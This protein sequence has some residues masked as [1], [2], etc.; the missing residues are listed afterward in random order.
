MIFISSTRSV[1]K[2]DTAFN[3]TYTP[4]ITVMLFDMVQCLLTFLK[5]ER[6]LAGNLNLNTYM[7]A[8]QQAVTFLL[9]F[10]HITYM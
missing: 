2:I 6:E 1:H 4:L 9:G 3:I 8:Q 7:S 5:D 10:A